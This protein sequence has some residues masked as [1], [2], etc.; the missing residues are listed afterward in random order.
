MR[1]VLKGA[2]T[3]GADTKKVYLNKLLFKEFQGCAKCTHTGKCM[4]NDDLTSVIDELRQADIWVLASPIYF[5]GITGQMKTFFDRCRTFT[6]DQDTQELKPQIEG[7][8]RA[9]LVLCLEIFTIPRSRTV[10]L[11]FGLTGIFR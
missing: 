7:K 10:I 5:D 4:L 8:R 1:A 3:A 9:V 11:I 2:G 6:K